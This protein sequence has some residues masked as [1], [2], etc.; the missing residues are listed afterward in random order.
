[1]NRN[2]DLS[3]TIYKEWEQDLVPGLY[4]QEHRLEDATVLATLLVYHGVQHRPVEDPST[5]RYKNHPRISVTSIQ[6]TNNH[7]I[8]T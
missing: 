4:L 3:G 1:M 6:N 2:I 5:N 7:I 8:R